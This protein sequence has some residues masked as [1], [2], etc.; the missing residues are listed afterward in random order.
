M[1]CAKKSGCADPE[2]IPGPTN[3]RVSHRPRAAGG[4]T[5][6]ALLH[7]A[8]L[9]QPRGRVPERPE[10]EAEGGLADHVQGRAAAGVADVV[11]L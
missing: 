6:T 5:A 8:A 10:V 11:C 9:P 1:P 4:G 7:A 2:A 3:L